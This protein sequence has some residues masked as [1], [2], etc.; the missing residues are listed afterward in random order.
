MVALVTSF[1]IDAAFTDSA[2]VARVISVANA[3]LKI[4]VLSTL[5]DISALIL[6]SKVFSAPFALSDSAAISDL[7][8]AIAASIS[9]A[10]VLSLLM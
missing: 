2:P 10:A 4:L 7:F 1:A 3:P 9:D 5:A 6:S 8:S